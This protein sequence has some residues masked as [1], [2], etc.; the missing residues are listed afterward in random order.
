MPQNRGLY[1]RVLV[2]AA[3]RRE[4]RIGDLRLMATFFEIFAT[5]FLEARFLL[6]FFFAALRVFFR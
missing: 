1:R 4:V 5:F 2:R 3:E 6:D